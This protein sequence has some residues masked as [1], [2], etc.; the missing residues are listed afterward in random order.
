M[1]NLANLAKINLFNKSIFVMNFEKW[2]SYKTINWLLFLLSSLLLAYTG[3]RASILSFTHDESFTFTHYVSASVANIISYNINPVIA[4]NHILNTLCMKLFSG[5]LGNSELILRLHSFLAHILYLWMTY[6]ILK[7]TNSRFILV[8]GFILLNVNP[9]LL[10][11]FS[12]AR[13]YGLSI[14]LMAGSL[15]CFIKFTQQNHLKLLIISLSLTLLAILANFSMISYALALFVVIELYF[16]YTKLPQKEFIKYN[17][18]I[19]VFLIVVF[20]IYFGPITVLKNRNEFYFGGSRGLWFDT[21]ISSI[22]CYLYETLF[23]E[24]L[25]YFYRFLVVF[26]SF[27]SM[28]IIYKQIKARALNVLSY[29]NLIFIVILCISVLQHV[30]MGGLFFISRVALFL[31]PL[32]FFSLLN[33]IFNDSLF[34]KKFGLF[35]KTIIIVTSLLSVFILVNGLKKVNIKEWNYDADT[36]TMLSDLNIF[37]QNNPHVKLGITW[38]FEPTINFYKNTHKLNWLQ[39]ANRDGLNGEYDYYYVEQND[40]NSFNKENKF[41]IKKYT[42]SGSELYKRI[43]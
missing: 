14:A 39:D 29:I 40:L 5:L 42:T 25:I 28:W 1:V 43:Y 8:F 7:T 12:L 32:F 26:V 6:S 4:N 27:A 35:S 2:F 37:R 3:Y 20:W 38:V 22:I 21:A 30:L 36:K 17:L 10:D 41:L 9:Y 24:S 18:H 31:V 19:V 16:I 34:S 23:F 33:I 11:F 15:Y 13:G